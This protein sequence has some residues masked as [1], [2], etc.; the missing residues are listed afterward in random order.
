MRHSSHRFGPVLCALL[1]LGVFL[2]SVTPSSAHGVSTPYNYVDHSHNFGLHGSSKKLARPVLPRTV[3]P[4]T[5]TITSTGNWSGFLVGSGSGNGF[6]ET[7]GNWN[8]PCT[9]GTIDHNHLAAEWVGL[10]G[11]YSDTLLQAGTTLLADGTFH[12]FYELYPNPPVINSQSFGCASSFTAEVDYNYSSTGTNKNH[13]FVKNTTTG[14]SM[15]VIVSNATFQPDLQSSE[16]V[17]E[18]PSCNSG[19]T[20]M[21]NFYFLGWTSSLART[22]TTGAGLATINTFAN[23]DL[24]MQD[25]QTATTLAKPDGLNLDGTFKD[26][27]YAAGSDGTC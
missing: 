5:T 14:A 13:I 12:M 16:W 11:Y 20:D 4:A 7:T 2:F 23:T 25:Q 6:N 19:L 21:A 3:S 10:G 9:S 17:N 15:D 24:M 26:R 18:R 22:N 1:A 27:W 8:T